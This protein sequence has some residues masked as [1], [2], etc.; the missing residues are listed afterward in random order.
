MD[1]V[2]IYQNVI[3]SMKAPGKDLTVVPL[4]VNVDF[5]ALWRTGPKGFYGPT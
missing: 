2:S 4:E 3:I 5:L 1:K